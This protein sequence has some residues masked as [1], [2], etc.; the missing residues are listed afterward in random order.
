MRFHKHLLPIGICCFLFGC[1]QRDTKKD[2]LDIYQVYGDVLDQ[3]MN[4]RLYYSCTVVDDR[5]ADSVFTMYQRG[6]IDPKIYQEIGDSLIS[7]RKRTPPKCILDYDTSRIYTQPIWSDSSTASTF[8]LQVFKE[9]FVK[10]NFNISF[11]IFIDSLSHPFNHFDK[12][13]IDYL[14]I[15]PYK[16]SH[17]PFGKGL[18]RF[19]FSKI[20][21]NSTLDKAILY[22]DIMISGKNGHGEALFIELEN[23]KWRVKEHHEFWIS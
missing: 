20:I 10:E 15:I 13:E 7:I 14:N 19:T 5:Y 17:G 8:L 2:P 6:E 18:G 12:I 9:K 11:E 21:F 23:N 22:Y 4:E 3:L 1:Q 16:K